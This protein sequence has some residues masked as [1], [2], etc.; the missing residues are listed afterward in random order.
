MK[1]MNYLH[2]LALLGLVT[3]MMTF[4]VNAATEVDAS[5]FANGKAKYTQLCQVC[6]G[7]KGHGDGPTSASLPHKPANI[8]NKLSG[9]FTSPSSLA[10]DILEGDVEQGMP[11]WKGTITKQDALDILT[12]VETIQ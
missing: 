1:H 10:D 8:A 4:N 7:D 2:L 5:Q 6:H 9:F 12:Y 11:A 3:S